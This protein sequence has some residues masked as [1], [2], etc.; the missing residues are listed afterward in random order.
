MVQLI[1]HIKSSSY[2]SAKISLVGGFSLDSPTER[3]VDKTR[4]TEN[5]GTSR[6]IPEHEKIKIIFME[7]KIKNKIIFVEINNNVK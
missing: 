7:K 6:N 2:A 4:N 1:P 3:G 5:S